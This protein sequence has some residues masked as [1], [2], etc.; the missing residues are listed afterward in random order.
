MDIYRRDQTCCRTTFVG[1]TRSATLDVVFDK[2]NLVAPLPLAW[3]YYFVAPL[4]C[5]IGNVKFLDCFDFFT[6]IAQTIR[7]INIILVV[8]E[9]HTGKFRLYNT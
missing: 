2:E 3:K 1:T 4:E 6:I 7:V 8:S 5:T 9:K